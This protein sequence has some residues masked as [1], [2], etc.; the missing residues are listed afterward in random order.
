MLCN[1]SRIGMVITWQL[2]DNLLTLSYLFC[3]Y[4]CMCC[5]LIRVEPGSL[6]LPFVYILKGGHCKLESGTNVES[7]V[8]LEHS[9]VVLMHM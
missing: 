9:K 7:D 4:T 8:S 1:F 2:I 6:C 3:V 5:T